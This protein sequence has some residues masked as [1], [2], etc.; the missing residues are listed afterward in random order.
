[1]VRVLFPVEGPAWDDSARAAFLLRVCTGML[2]VVGGR[3]KGRMSSEI[4]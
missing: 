4:E 2:S 3:W 1:M